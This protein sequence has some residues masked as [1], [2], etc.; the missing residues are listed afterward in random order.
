M[1][2][3]SLLRSISCRIDGGTRMLWV[4]EEDVTHK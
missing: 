4:D 3:F 1:V 2:S